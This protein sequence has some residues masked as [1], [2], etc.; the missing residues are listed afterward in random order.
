MKLFLH[1][2]WGKSGTTWLQNQVFSQKKFFS[3]FHKYKLHNLVDPSWGPY[4][5]DEV[6]KIFTEFICQAAR[7]GLNTYVSSEGIIGSL[8]HKPEIHETMI[9]RIHKVYDGE[10]KI[11]LFIRKH[12]NILSSLYIAHLENYNNISF[13]KFL[14]RYHKEIR[15]LLAYSDRIRFCQNLFGAE[16]VFVG[17]LE[18]LYV[19]PEK[20]KDRF[21]KFID[22]DLDNFDPQIKPNSKSSY[23]VYEK[24]RWMTPF[25]IRSMHSAYHRYFGRKSKKSSEFFLNRYRQA[26]SKKIEYQDELRFRNYLK[27]EICKHHNEFFMKDV[28]CLKEIISLDLKSIWSSTKIYD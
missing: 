15:Y 12:E 16:N 24:T 11:I 14:K 23:L 13:K 9:N 27:D 25:W 7:K 20:L 3:S 4:D 2:G 1:L 5:E 10:K 19:S 22:Q 6:K 21:Q 8:R 26:I 17:A 28:E 18:E